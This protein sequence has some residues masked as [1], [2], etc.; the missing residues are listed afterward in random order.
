MFHRTK[1]QGPPA[2]PFAHADGC[3]ILAAD[4][5][6]E[7]PWSRH[8][9]G[10]WR[11]ECRCGA[12][13]W[14]ELAPSRVRLDPL[15]P[16]TAHHAGQCEFKDVADPDVIRVLLKITPKEGYSWVECGN[17]DTGWQVPHYAEA[18]VG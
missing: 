16:A 15:D 9:Y 1:H 12:E 4:P 18:S 3:R 17:C 11:R 2:G 14:Q 5:D 13:S 10:L 7:I 6:V 8:E